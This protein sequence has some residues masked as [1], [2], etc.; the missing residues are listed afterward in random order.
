MTPPSILKLSWILLF[1]FFFN[2]H[3]L[4]TYNNN[5]VKEIFYDLD[6][7][8]E[9]FQDVL[10]IQPE[11]IHLSSPWEHNKDKT[12]TYK[13]I[14]YYQKLSP[15][16]NVHN[17][18]SPRFIIH[19]HVITGQW[20]FTEFHA[21]PFSR[22]IMTFG[23]ATKKEKDKCESTQKASISYQDEW[24]VMKEYIHTL[25]QKLKKQ[26]INIQT[27]REINELQRL[28][29]QENNVKNIKLKENIKIKTNTKM[30][31]KDY[32]NNELLI[33]KNKV[34]E[35][36]QNQKSNITEFKQEI[37]KLQN[38]IDVLSKSNVKNEQI[39]E[40]K[41]QIKENEILDLTN[42]IVTTKSELEK[43]KTLQSNQHRTHKEKIFSMK[44][45]TFSNMSQFKLK[46]EQM[47]KNLAFEKKQN[48]KKLKCFVN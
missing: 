41:L 24:K 46:K 35:K 34:K 19:Q 12:G 43:L 25:E 33:I 48:E 18:Q 10:Q 45:Q 7:F 2:G 13:L 39:C 20:Q 27:L 38:E 9:K 17:C 15:E 42:I 14:P 4:G 11:Y 5:K 3:V 6:E 22:A 31:E 44:K 8:A 32:L 1:S 16:L 36:F 47:K 28:K 26:E 30:N 23:N 21:Y 29:I 37:K 40:E